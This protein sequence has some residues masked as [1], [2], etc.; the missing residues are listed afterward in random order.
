[1]FELY[2]DAGSDATIVSGTVSGL[3]DDYLLADGSRELT[4]DWDAGS[5]KITAEQLESDV[6]SG[7][8]PFITASPTLVDN[9]N[10]DMVDGY[11]LDQVLVSGSS[12][13]F[14]GSNFS[15]L[16]ASG[17]AIADTGGYF[18]PMK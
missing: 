12:P 6:G 14:D 18:R 3:L 15:N 10:A 7:T 4:S 17:V 5:Y 1:L 13:Y 9:L 2:D 11:H 8:A 16:H